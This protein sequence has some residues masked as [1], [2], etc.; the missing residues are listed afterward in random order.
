MND[1]GWQEWWPKDLPSVQRRFT[2]FG[3]G[4]GY[5]LLSWLHDRGMNAVR[6]G[7][8]IRLDTAKREDARLSP[9]DWLV[10]GLA[11]D[12]TDIYPRQD[13]VNAARFQRDKP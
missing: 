12:G 2:G 1:G 6:D 10:D 9:G 4:N 11:D 3:D 7:D 8:D 13:K 5:A